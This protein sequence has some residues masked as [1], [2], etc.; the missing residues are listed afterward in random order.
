MGI[1]LAF[2]QSLLQD[3]GKTPSPVHRFADQ[4][5][6]FPTLVKFL[7]QTVLAYRP[8]FPKDAS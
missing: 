6:S 5:T 3:E 7:Q 1:R 8:D 4:D 2:V